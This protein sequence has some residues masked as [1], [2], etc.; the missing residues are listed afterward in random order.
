MKFITDL[1][2]VPKMKKLDPE[3]K[4]FSVVVILKKGKGTAPP[5]KSVIL[6]NF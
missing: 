2:N 5:V 3:R 1:M 6:S 4:E